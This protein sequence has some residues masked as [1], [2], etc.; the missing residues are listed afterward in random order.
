[1]ATLLPKPN[2]Y[3]Y[4][5]YT[6]HQF[7]VKELKRTDFAFVGWSAVNTKAVDRWLADLHVTLLSVGLAV[8]KDR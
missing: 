4:I 2:F 6:N 8:Y 1:M 7:G 5:G 3:D